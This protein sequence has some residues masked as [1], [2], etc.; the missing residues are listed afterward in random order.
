MCI[1][2]VCLYVCDSREKG[3]EKEEEKGRT[4]VRVCTYLKNDLQ[5]ACNTYER[6][7]FPDPMKKN[8]D[9]RSFAQI[10]QVLRDPESDANKKNSRSSIESTSLCI[11]LTCFQCK[12]FHK[13]DFDTPDKK[14]TIE[15]NE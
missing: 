5:L 1:C 12:L 3:A 14:R 13:L 4:M 7:I 10:S 11:M 6:E 2:F 15:R 8:G 9:K